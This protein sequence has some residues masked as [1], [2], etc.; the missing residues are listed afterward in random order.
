MKFKVLIQTRH[1]LNAASTAGWT[2][3]DSAR[4]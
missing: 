2:A 1:N 3:L 4:S